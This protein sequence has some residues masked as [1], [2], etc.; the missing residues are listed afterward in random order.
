MYKTNNLIAQL[1]LMSD[2]KFLPEFILVPGKLS[3]Y[4]MTDELLVS[5]VQA[6]TSMKQHDFDVSPPAFVWNPKWTLNIATLDLNPVT[7]GLKPRKA[8]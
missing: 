6:Y 7:F 1:I 2:W 5:E 3:F 8:K 4:N